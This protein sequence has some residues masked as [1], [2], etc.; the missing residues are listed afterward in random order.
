MI[1]Q[2]ERAKLVESFRDEPLYRRAVTAKCAACL[3]ILAGIAAIGADGGLRT[4]ETPAGNASTQDIHDKR[5]ARSDA[6]MA[7]GNVN[8]P[9]RPTFEVQLH[10]TAPQ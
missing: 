6:V 10:P 2:Q 4:S 7:R 9:Q 5:V 3:L 8:A 1:T